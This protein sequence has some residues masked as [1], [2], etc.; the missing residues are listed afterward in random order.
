MTRQAP[1]EPYDKLV[2][3]SSCLTLFFLIQAD[4]CLLFTV[5]LSYPGLFGME[6]LN[7]VTG[8]CQTLYSAV[9]LT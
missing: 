6:I 4:W 1:A 9:I 8:S 7:I 5:I 2:N 3:I